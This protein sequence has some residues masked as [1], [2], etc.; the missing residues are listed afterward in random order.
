[1]IS[2]PILD[3]SETPPHLRYAAGA[4]AMAQALSA[5]LDAGRDR[6]ACRTLAHAHD[7]SSLAERM[8]RVLDERMAA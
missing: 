2:T 6:Q 8:V 7:W 5:T 1:V 3:L 4:T